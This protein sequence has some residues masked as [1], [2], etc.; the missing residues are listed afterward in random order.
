VIAGK[1]SHDSKTEKGV[2]VFAPFTSILRTLATNGLNVPAESLY[3]LFRCPSLFSVFDDE[4]S[5]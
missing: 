1:I 5:G 3:Q 2:Q 4:W